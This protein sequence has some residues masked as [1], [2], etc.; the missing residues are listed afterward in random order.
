L[1]CAAL[2]GVRDAEAKSKREPLVI[3]PAEEIMLSG[4][5]PRFGNPD[6]CTT[7][8]PGATRRAFRLAGGAWL[9]GVGCGEPDDRSYWFLQFPG[10]TPLEP[11]LLPDPRSEGLRAGIDGLS[12]ATFDFDNGT[13]RAGHFTRPEQDCG[14]LWAW[15]WTTGGWRLLE[16]RDM[17]ICEGRPVYDW[18][19]TYRREAVVERERD[20]LDDSG[21][22]L[23][24][25]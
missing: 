3:F 19:V 8:T 13:L 18:V 16:R 10:D 20:I 22:G 12:H 9:L 6:F 21:P 17:A 5:P 24:P 11:L 4:V 7:E 14:T 2:I 25:D 1:F 23:V 15:G